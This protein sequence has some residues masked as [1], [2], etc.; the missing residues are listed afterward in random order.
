MLEQPFTIVL[1]SPLPFSID[2]R[3]DMHSNDRSG[4]SPS[5]RSPVKQFVITV[6][7]RH[8]STHLSTLSPYFWSINMQEWVQNAFQYCIS[9]C[10]IAMTPRPHLTSV[11]HTWSRMPVIRRFTWWSFTPLTFSFHSC[12][13]SRGITVAHAALHMRPYMLADW[14]V[15]HI[16]SCDSK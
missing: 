9:W 16:G 10:C 7:L 5:I 12:S 14:Y 1:F 6:S 2:I 15:G 8:L 11:V 13:R 4:A 3:C